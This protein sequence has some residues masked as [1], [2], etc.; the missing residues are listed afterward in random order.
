MQSLLFEKN[1]RSV[2]AAE[3]GELQQQGYRLL[4]VR[5][6]EEWEEAHIEA[7]FPAQPFRPRDS[8]G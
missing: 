5:P 1:V 8:G 4:D 3:L 6:R 2:E 7:R